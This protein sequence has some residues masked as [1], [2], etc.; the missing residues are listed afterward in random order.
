MSRKDA[1]CPSTEI[2]GKRQIAKSKRNF[3]LKKLGVSS[4]HMNP[5]E[6]KSSLDRNAQSKDPLFRVKGIE[7][8]RRCNPLTITG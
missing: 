2:N 3:G 8:F 1:T 5:E 7:R 6:M 4:D